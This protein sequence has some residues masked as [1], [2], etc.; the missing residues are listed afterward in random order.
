MSKPRSLALVVAKEI[1]ELFDSAARLARDLD[2]ALAT[3]TPAEGLAL[4]LSSNGLELVDPAFGVRAA[5]RAEFLSGRLG[6][7][8][9]QGVG[10]R[11]PLGRA[12][13]AT[14]GLRPSVV[15]ATAGLGRDS[16]LLATLGCDVRA[17]ERSPVVAALLA[18]GLARA[19]A[20]CRQFQATD[21][22]LR[23]ARAAGRVSLIRADARSWLAALEPGS[24]PD[25]I[26]L[27]PMFPERR[28]S[29]LVKKE[30]RVFR[31]LVGDDGDAGEL[32]DVALQSAT[33]R[34]VVKR[35]RD[36]R[37]L[38]ASR[39]PDHAHDAGVTR[40]DVYLVED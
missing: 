25:V 37:A 18:D 14:A 17:V 12:V 2:C 16:L 11:E 31:Q 4:H 5:I 3:E 29:A 22:D 7:R 10:R 20:A 9:R 38:H 26:L 36:V 13:G 6:Y 15:D 40:F 19:R 24:R 27:D 39:T 28:R 33:R 8:L 23:V 21:A 35:P 1:P 34:V 32:L 30:M